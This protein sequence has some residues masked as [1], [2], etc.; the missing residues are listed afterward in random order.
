MNTT[1]NN[2]I[3]AKLETEAVLSRDI[4]WRA[5]DDYLAIITDECDGDDY[6]AIT[7][8]ENNDYYDYDKDDYLA[9]ITEESPGSSTARSRIKSKG[10]IN[11]LVA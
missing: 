8:T 2:Q 3:R 11:C 6:W 9:I 7:I 10:S 1:I 5:E 4:N